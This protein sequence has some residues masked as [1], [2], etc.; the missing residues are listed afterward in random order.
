MSFD[1]SAVQHI[2]Q[3]A[4][5]PEYLKQLE[6]ANTQVPAIILP[7]NMNTT[8]LEKYMPNASRY[9]MNFNTLSISDFVRYNTK[10]DVDGA[11][12]F[13]DGEDMSAKTIFD[14]GTEEAPLHKEH[15]ASLNLKPSAAFNAITD[16]NGRSKSQKDT[17][18]FIE[19][20]ADLI[21]VIDRDDQ[22]MTASAAAKSL[23]ELTI[24]TARA[25]SSKVGDFSESMSAM[26]SIEAKSNGQMPSKLIFKCTPYLGLGERE[27]SVQLSILTSGD[28]PSISTRI[29]QFETLKEEITEEFKDL[30]IEKFQKLKLETY[31]G[32]A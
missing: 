22:V 24:E 12:C 14:L 15:K 5:I 4:H 20:W 16:I 11:T 10:F 13:V 9:R 7:D 1:K 3:T 29:I 17:S 19:D 26:E 30:L 21:T 27:I 28:R 8:S 23:R 2:Q 18:D 25:L 31:I 6:A 32:Q